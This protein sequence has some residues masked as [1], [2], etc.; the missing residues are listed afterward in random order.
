MK[1]GALL[2]GE[3]REKLALGFGGRLLGLA[4]AARAG[5]RER[6]DLPAAVAWVAAAG[7]EAVVLE[8]VEKGDE[9]R[10]VETKRAGELASVR[11]SSLLEPVEDCE[12]VAAMSMAS[13]DWLKP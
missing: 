1:L 7:D 9:V 4:K 5:G 6:N 2:L 11:R 13:S 3:G 10:G 8:L 12:L